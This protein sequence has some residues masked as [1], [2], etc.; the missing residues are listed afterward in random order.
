M[1]DEPQPTPP[2][3]GR[4]TRARSSA[5]SAIARMAADSSRPRAS[6][7]TD[8]ATSGGPPQPSAPARTTFAAVVHDS[9]AGVTAAHLGTRGC[10]EGVKAAPS[11]GGHVR[12]AGSVHIIGDL[13]AHYLQQLTNGRKVGHEVCDGAGHRVV[14]QQ[15]GSGPGPGPDHTPRG[16]AGRRGRGVLRQGGTGLRAAVSGRSGHRGGHRLRR[17]RRE[18]R[19]RGSA[20]SPRTRGYGRRPRSTVWRQP[21]NCGCRRYGCAPTTAR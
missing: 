10:T 19:G 16:H 20:V 14:L 15:D 12:G 11:G 21:S 2:S 18:R 3:P 7:G 4:R 13:I 5:P 1:A 8:R 9:R 17:A 6:S